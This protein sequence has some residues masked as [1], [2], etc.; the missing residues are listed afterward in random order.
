[1]V[2]S[3]LDGQTMDRDYNGARGIFLR[4]LGDNPILRSA[5]SRS[6]SDVSAPLTTSCSS[7]QR[8]FIGKKISICY[9]RKKIPDDATFLN[10]VRHEAGHLCLSALGIDPGNYGNAH[11]AIFAAA[12]YGA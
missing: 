9:D 8:N 12:N 10:L 1:M 11:H 4:A 6:A 2:K 5:L 3:K 7:W